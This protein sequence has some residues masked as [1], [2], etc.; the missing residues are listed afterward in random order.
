MC[1]QHKFTSC[2]DLERLEDSADH[3]RLKVDKEIQIMLYQS[4]AIILSQAYLVLYLM[5]NYHVE[6]RQILEEFIVKRVIVGIGISLLAN[7]VALLIHIHSHKA[8]LIE[9]WNK[10]WKRHLLA[11]MLGGIMS[12]CYF[13]AVLLSIFVRFAQS[14]KYYVK[15][16]SDP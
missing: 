16:C 5:N 11:L 9:V 14:K 10:Q 13:T 2:T 6:T 4:T 1:F 3:C 15:N 12:I 7:F 8:C